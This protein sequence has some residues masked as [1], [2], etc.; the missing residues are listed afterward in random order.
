VEEQK[1]PHKII[2]NQF[3]ESNQE[4]LIKGCCVSNEQLVSSKKCKRTVSHKQ[5]K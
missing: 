4:T 2:M 5:D 3:F 1:N